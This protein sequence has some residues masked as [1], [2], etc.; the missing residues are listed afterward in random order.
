M[1]SLMQASEKG[2]V[3][4]ESAVLPCTGSDTLVEGGA[5][6]LLL[7]GYAGRC[8]QGSTVG[9]PQVTSTALRYTLKSV[10]RYQTKL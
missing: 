2:E 4:L 6:S 1:R 10:D 9:L 7:P 3:R 8:I 5:Y